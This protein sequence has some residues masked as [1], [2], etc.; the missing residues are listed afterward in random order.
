MQQAK[1]K[2]ASHDTGKGKSSVRGRTAVDVTGGTDDVPEDTGSND[3]ADVE[4]ASLTSRVIPVLVAV[5]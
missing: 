4:V 1:T 3:A 2:T 5:R